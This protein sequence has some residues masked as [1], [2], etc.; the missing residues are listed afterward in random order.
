MNPILYFVLSPILLAAIGIFIYF[1]PEKVLRKT[2][3]ISG[4]I[5]ALC[6]SFWCLSL[7]VHPFIAGSGPVFLLFPLLAYGMGYDL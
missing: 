2:S 6:L 1:S 4:F 7:G 5:I 3:L